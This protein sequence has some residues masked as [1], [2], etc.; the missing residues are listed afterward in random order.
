MTTYYF[1]IIEFGT[2]SVGGTG[3]P[4]AIIRRVDEVKEFDDPQ[5]A[6]S[7]WMHS[8]CDAYVSQD[9]TNEENERYEL[10]FKAR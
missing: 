1:G 9:A 6:F 8:G 4:L 3:H 10:T 7:H 2:F 5:D